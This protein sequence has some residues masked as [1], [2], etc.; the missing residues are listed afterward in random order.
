MLNCQI[1]TFVMG[2]PVKTLVL[3]LNK[4]WSNERF[5]PTKDSVGKNVIHNIFVSIKIQHWYDSLTDTAK[6]YDTS[7]NTTGI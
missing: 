7:H 1:Y 5:L 2:Q 6:V 3:Q 4:I